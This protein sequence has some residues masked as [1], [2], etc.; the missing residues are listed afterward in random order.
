MILKIKAEGFF[1][2][3]LKAAAGSLARPPKVHH[4]KVAAQRQRPS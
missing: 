2:E 1:D 3:P 4:L